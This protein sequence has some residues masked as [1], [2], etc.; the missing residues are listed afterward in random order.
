MRDGLPH[1]WTDKQRHEL[2]VQHIGGAE[3]DAFACE[4]AKLSLILADYPMVNGW[5]IEETDLF[6]KGALAARLERK[7]VILCNPP[8]PAFTPRS[9]RIIPQRRRLTAPR[10]SS[11][12]QPHCKHDRR[13]SVSLCRIRYW[14]TVAIASNGVRWN[15]LYREIE[16]VSLPDGVFNV[17]Q[18]D[19]AL[20]IA[21]DLRSPG[22]PRLIRSS[23]VY[24]ADKRR[25]ALDRTASHTIEQVRGAERAF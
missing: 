2:L 7:D 14:S 3:I 18:L 10:R 1:E 6:A 9:G 12:L 19:T 22:E 20:L 17:S 5:Q 13:C 15:E 24:D 21:R 11:R 25:F 16:L 8:F 23:A 4:I